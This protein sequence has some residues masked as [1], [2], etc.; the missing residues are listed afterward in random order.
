MRVGRL[1]ACAAAPGVSLKGRCGEAC[2]V[3]Q[4]GV[5]DLVPT[6][7]NLRRLVDILRLNDYAVAIDSRFSRLELLV[8]AS[9]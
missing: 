4:V 3:D 2:F 7:S 8:L 6:E 5:R 9:D 1:L